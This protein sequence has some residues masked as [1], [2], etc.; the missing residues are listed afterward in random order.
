MELIKKRAELAGIIERLRSEGKQIGFVPTMGALHEGHLSLIRAAAECDVV[1]CSIFVN[2]VQF[3]DASDLEKYPRILDQ[4]MALLSTEKCDYVFAPSV[5]E[6]YPEAPEEK[7]DFGALERVMEGAHRPGH[8]NGVAVVVK[9]LF[10][11]VRP[12]KAYFGLKDFQQLRIIEKLVETEQIPVEIVPCSIVR[13]NDGLAMSSRNRRLKEEE[14]AIAPQIHRILKES[15]THY[16][17]AGVF[18]CMEWVRDQIGQIPEFRLEY[19]QIVERESL[20]P[21]A[22]GDGS[23]QHVGCIALHL[24]NVRLIDNIDYSQSVQ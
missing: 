5:E 4:D 16:K 18:Q 1:V 11:M 19:F 12:H 20:Q 14:R 3:N 24:G 15:V 23:M 2:P 22:E 9:R 17:K 13:E 8:F 6:M 10:D 7:Y 21:V